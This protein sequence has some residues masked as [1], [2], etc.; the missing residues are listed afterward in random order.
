MKA[1]Q[2]LRCL[3]AMRPG[4]SAPPV[5][6]RHASGLVSTSGAC[7]PCVRAG[8]HLRCLLA[9]RPGWSAPPVLA[10]HAAGTNRNHFITCELVDMVLKTDRPGVRN[11]SRVTNA[12][13]AV[14]IKCLVQWE[15]SVLGLLWRLC[16]AIVEFSQKSCREKVIGSI[17]CRK[18][19]ETQ[20]RD[21]A[22]L[23]RSIG[24]LDT[25]L[26]L[27]GWSAPSVP[28]R[29]CNRTIC[30][31]YPDP[32]F[33][34]GAGKWGIVGNSRQLLIDRFSRLRYVRVAAVEVQSAGHTVFLYP[35]AEQREYCGRV[36]LFSEESLDNIS[37]IVYQH[38]ETGWRTVC[39]EPAVKTPISLHHEAET[40]LTW[41][42]SSLR[43]GAPTSLGEQAPKVLTHSVHISN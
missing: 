29:P 15:V 31:D 5:L 18:T 21:Q 33:P 10:R 27:R 19:V 16:K 4:W 41:T 38:N 37:G 7:S 22:P 13:Q 20:S 36:F 2:H 11:G 39:S 6:A 25:S 26:G 40:G 14:H 3:L 24:P 17:N 23:K 9:M 42:Q 35:S 30:I 43:P 32:E 1:G 28:A 12:K 34:A 8:Q